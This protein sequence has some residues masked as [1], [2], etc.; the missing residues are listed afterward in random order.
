MKKKLTA[1][2]LIE[3]AN[4]V[5]L[6]LAVIFVSGF[7]NNTHAQG[8]YNN[9]A[10]I[11]ITNG[12]YF[13]I[14]GA[15]DG[16]YLNEDAGGTQDGAIDIDG[17]IHIEGDWLNNAGG[18]NVLINRDTDGVVEF[19]GAS[20]QVI[21]G[22]RATHFENLT[23][24]N[25]SGGSAI[26]LGGANDQVV[27]EVLTLT[28]GYV[29]TGANNILYVNDDAAT[30]IL[31]QSNASFIHG[32]LR[33]DIAMNTDTYSFPVGKTATAADYHPM[34]IINNNLQGTTNITASVKDITEAGNDID[35]NLSTAEMSTPLD[36]LLSDA[37]WVIYPDIQPT[38]STTF[39]VNLYVVNVAE[40]S[41]ADD[42]RFTT[43]KRADGSTNYAD[44]D[45]HDPTTA[46]PSAGSPGRVYNLGNG[47]AQKT[48]F[49]SFS[50]FAIAKSNVGPLPVELI[51]FTASAMNNRQAL[52]EWTTASEIDNDF[53]T[54]ER[55]ID[56]QDWEIVGHIQG[57]GTTDEE[58]SYFLIDQ[59][60][61][62][63]LTYYRLKQTD[64]NGQFQY[65]EIRTVKFNVTDLFIYSIDNQVVIEY[66]GDQDVAKVE[67]INA[68][69]QRVSNNEMSL[70]KGINFLS[71]NNLPA[72]VYYVRLK[73]M[74]EGGVYNERILLVSN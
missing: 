16:G 46:I 25:S 74:K 54:V 6:A 13:Y 7:L 17:T 15:S 63:P 23:I 57:M 62:L 58:H 28:D 60:P 18:G 19:S 37:V 2:G 72:G 67:I 45:T 49:D 65:S 68:L 32:N 9:G 29:T 31:G 59:T 26:T 33:R 10:S 22:S 50:E 27:E 30:S 43:V 4:L 38:N 41:I 5:L 1:V 70:M 21:G 71:V 52:T 36:N 35:A 3:E 69:G 42:D 48:G 73:L 53:F 66:P 39:G 12:T 64:F 61:Y 47:Y 44:W 40:L 24:N 55:A 51:D 11:V 8:V 34:D 14:D 56:G 20:A